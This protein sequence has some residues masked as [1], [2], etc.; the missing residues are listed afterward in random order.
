MI[1]G[2]P[3]CGRG[4]YF[5]DAVLQNDHPCHVLGSWR[6]PGGSGGPLGVLGRPLGTGWVA[7]VRTWAD[8]GRIFGLGVTSVCRTILISV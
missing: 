2:T 3:K 6:R 1:F 7:G 4:C 5:R 8:W